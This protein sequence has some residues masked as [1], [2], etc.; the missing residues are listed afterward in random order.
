MQEY[1]LYVNPQKPTVGLYVRAGASL[2]DLA[3]PEQWV[4]D[5]T[6]TPS[7][8]P[9]D[10]VKISKLMVTPSGSWDDP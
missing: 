2:S 10:L 8:L 6:F 9:A 4:F 3:H 5:G 7:D 1:D